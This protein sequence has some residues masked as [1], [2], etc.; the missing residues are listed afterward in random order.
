MREVFGLEGKT[1]LVVGGGYGSGRLTAMLL[2]RAGAKVAV[3]DID[4][5]RARSVAEEIGGFAIQGD[6]T[7]VEGANAVVDAAQAHLGGLS[8]LANIVGLVGMGAFMD[9]DAAH[10]S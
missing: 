3:A 2:A 4:E 6:V 10:W 5:G 8:R 1:A 7:S 9:T